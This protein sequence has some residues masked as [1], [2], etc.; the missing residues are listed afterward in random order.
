MMSIVGTPVVVL[1]IL[2]GVIVAFSILLTR[3]ALGPAFEALQAFLCSIVF[4]TPT[5]ATG[6]KDHGRRTA[7][8][9]GLS[10]RSEVL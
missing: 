5:S 6:A 4:V 3:S 8:S 2:I 1:V 9:V 10:G 7:T